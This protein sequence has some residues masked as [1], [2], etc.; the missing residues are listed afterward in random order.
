MAE[1][2]SREPPASAEAD[3]STGQSAGGSPHCPHRKFMQ[4]YYV[5]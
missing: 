4:T 1:R 2:E 3:S 5:C